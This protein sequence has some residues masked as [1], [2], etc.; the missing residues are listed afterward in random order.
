MT[1]RVKILFVIGRLDISGEAG[2]TIDLALGFRRAQHEVGVLAAG[3]RRL[4]RLREA[5]VKVWLYPALY[6]TWR[7]FA[8]RAAV[9]ELARFSPQILHIQSS[10]AVAAGRRLARALKL[11]AVVTVHRDY[12]GGPRPLGAEIRAVIAISESLRENLVN[13]A[14][15]PK[16]L[17]YVVPD[18]IDV[19]RYQKPPPENGDR[20]PVVLGMG[21]LEPRRGFGFF[22]EAAAR[23]L[24]AGRPAQFVLIGDGPERSGLVRRAVELGVRES[25]VFPGAIDDPR[26]ALADMDIF[27]HPALAEALGLPV[28]EAMATGRP[29]ITTGVGGSYTLAEDGGNAFV[30]PAAN[31]EALAE[32]IVQ[33]IDE[34]DLRLE[35]GRRGT[36]IARERFGISM[37]VQLTIE[38]YQRLVREQA[39][40]QAIED[41]LS[42]GGGGGGGK[43]SDQ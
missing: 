25:M 2:H 38:I 22:I 23:V 34:P 4:E 19:E 29:V 16:E 32:R 3:G 8:G 39:E 41:A 18:G 5:G 6:S 27:V 36:E 15:V 14:A 31:A 9:A 12:T 20:L 10:S 42:A 7:P 33:L 43:K 28:L 35:M 30:V 13:E 1:R 37:V 40:T 24:D 17:I 26:E 21:R 11:P